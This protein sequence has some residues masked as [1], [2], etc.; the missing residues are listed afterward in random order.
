MRR[1]RIEWHEYAK[2]HDDDNMQDSTPSSSLTQA[3]CHD[4]SQVDIQ[5]NRVL[6]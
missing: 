3:S 5:E 1:K 6:E 2:H 4:D